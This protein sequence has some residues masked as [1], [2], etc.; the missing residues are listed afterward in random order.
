MI[1]LKVTELTQSRAACEQADAADPLRSWRDR[2]HLLKGLIYLDGNSLGP[3]PRTATKYLEQTIH[4]E[5]AEDLISSWNKA[6][7][8]ELPETLGERL[9]P[10]LGTTKGQVVV[11]DSVS[12]NLFKAVHAALKLRSGRTVIVSEAEGFPTDLYMLEGIVGAQHGVVRRLLGKDGDTFEELLDDKVA[13]V[14]VSHANYRTG[15]LLP[16]AE[17]AEKTHAAG[18]LLVV[19]V[20]HTAGAV[21]IQCDEWGI[22]FAVGC[23]YKYLN[24]GP[25]SPAFLYVAK[26]HQE[27]ATNPLPG[28]CGHA[29]PFAFELGYEAAAG[30]SR[31]RTGTQPILA[32]RGAQAGLEIAGAADMELVREKSQRLTQLFAELAVAWLTE[33]GVTLASPR[34][35]ERRGSQIAL[36]FEE[37]YSV[38]QALIARKI[39]A[40]FRAPGLMR[41]G[42]APLYLRYTDV[43]D[44]AV[45]LQEVLTSG[46]WRDERFQ[47]QS[48]VT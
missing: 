40:D 2:F 14:V 4:R 19:D 8:W 18:A 42:F 24:G 26:Q 37:G 12:V 6:G 20:C 13:V 45:A 47:Q 36:Y 44:A 30:I 38:I 21:P 5:W 48:A 11:V 27:Q 9:A 25:G 46:E 43:W 29:R 41:F 3:M 31:F 32:F 1:M 28:W 15:E 10:V 33:H 23:T 34:D 16:I 7:W 35:P 22:D 39:V 17:L